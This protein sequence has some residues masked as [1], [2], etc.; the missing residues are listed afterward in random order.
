MSVKLMQE[1]NGRTLIVQPEGKLTRDDYDLFVPETER[2]ILQ[3]GKIDVLFDLERFDGWEAGAL[4]EDIKFD[5]KHF[6]DVNRLAI[7]GHK[8]W[9]EWMSTICKP[10]TTAEV[11]FF[12]IED[13]DDA[14]NWIRAGAREAKDART[15]SA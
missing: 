6:S 3:H 10:F 11:R 9:H 8:K 14:L 7:L 1:N 2:Q 13:R 15:A 12:Q 4:W 5:L